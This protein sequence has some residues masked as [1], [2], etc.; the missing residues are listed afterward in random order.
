MQGPVCF[1]GQSQPLWRD[2]RHVTSS[3]SEN[4]VAQLSRGRVSQMR[5]HHLRTDEPSPEDLC[6][7]GS[8]P[9]AHHVTK[10]ELLMIPVLSQTSHSQWPHGLCRCMRLTAECPPSHAELGQRA[11]N[12]FLFQLHWTAFQNS[13][14]KSKRSAL[15]D[16]VWARS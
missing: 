4:D 16:S 5:P 3:D 9:T 2:F 7:P 8:C 1:T 6:F 12:R 10:L 13:V 11:S 15:D 14:Q